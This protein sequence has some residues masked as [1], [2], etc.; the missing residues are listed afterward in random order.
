MTE[1]AAF[2][3]PHDCEM[4]QRL[5]RLARRRDS[6]I[7]FAKFLGEE[8]GEVGRYLK[9]DFGKGALLLLLR[10]LRKR[11]KTNSL[12]NKKG[13]NTNFNSQGGKGGDSPTFLR[14][15]PD[16][17]RGINARRAKGRSKSFFFYVSF[18]LL[19]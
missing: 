11:G 12:K 13:D 8:N 4:R 7:D 17:R 3:I 16:G 19:R 6:T 2:A 1:N 5:Q 14:G 9:T 15:N 18:K 10:L